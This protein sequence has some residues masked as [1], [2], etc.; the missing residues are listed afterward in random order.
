MKII[1]RVLYEIFYF[2]FLIFVGIYGGL[3][4]SKF[5]INTLNYSSGN[6][7]SFYIDTERVNE[8]QCVMFFI[9]WDLA[10]FVNLEFSLWCKKEFN[11]V[12]FVRV[13]EDNQVILDL[14]YNI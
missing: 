6:V 14:F 4:I 3:Y 2:S 11:R 5:M 1:G 9:V 12:F 8:N 7:S 10:P 13:L